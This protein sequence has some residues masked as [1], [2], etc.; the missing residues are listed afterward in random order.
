MIN[1]LPAIHHFSWFNLERK[2]NTYKNYWSK[3][4][5]SLYNVSQDDTAENNMFFN[6]PW[7]DVTDEEITD[8]ASDLAEK[9]GGWIF[10]RKLDLNQ[11]TP[12]I[13]CEIGYP[14]I[15]ENWIK[16]NSKHSE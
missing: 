2:I 11:P 7:S 6:K 12:Y 14:S 9:T 3:H 10:H 15:M 1:N 5:Q 8:L 13:D 4:W 16:K